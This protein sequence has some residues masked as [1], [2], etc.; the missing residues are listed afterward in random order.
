[1]NKI[2]IEFP[3][4]GMINEKFISTFGITI[5]QLMKRMFGGEKLPILVKGT[6][7]Q[8]KA[9]ARAMVREK[10]HYKMYK[11]YGLDSPKTYRSKFMLKRAVSQFEKKTGMKWPLKFR[12]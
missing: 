8:V 1:M 11:K 12:N 3:P 2:V 4:E 5:K 6:P 9:F 7:R 10:D